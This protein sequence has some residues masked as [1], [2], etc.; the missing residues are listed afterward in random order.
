MKSDYRIRAQKFLKAIYPLIED[1]LYSPYTL[2][3]VLLRYAYEHNR[4]ITVLHGATRCAIITSDYVIKWDYADE[5]ILADLGGVE[6]E[7]EIYENACTDGYGYLFAETMLVTYCNTT[8][9]IMPRIR[10]I[11]ARAHKMK[12]IWDMLTHDE[13]HYVENVV[14]DLHSENWGIMHNHPVIID[15]ACRPQDSN[16]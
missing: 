4:N 9:S 13:W 6:V 11:G 2:R 14:D 15:Y 12:N 7:S 16:W 1:Y 3:D 10:N 5:D 8:F